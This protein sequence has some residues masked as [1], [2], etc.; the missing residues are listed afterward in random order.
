MAVVRAAADGARRY[1]ARP[2]IFHLH[3]VTGA[4]A[5]E[6]LAAHIRPRTAPPPW[7]A[8]TP[9]TPRCTRP[10]NR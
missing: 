7:P 9:S 8:C 1:L 6:I 10:P 4:M 3:G 5:V 2:D